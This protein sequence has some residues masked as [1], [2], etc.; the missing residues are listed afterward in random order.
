MSIL[1]H[2]KS[3]ANLLWMIVNLCALLNLLYSFILKILALHSQ[4]MY[5]SNSFIQF[6]IIYICIYKSYVLK[7]LPTIAV[8]T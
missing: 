7:N 2:T 3:F 8:G 6:N 5:L 4:Q 1:C